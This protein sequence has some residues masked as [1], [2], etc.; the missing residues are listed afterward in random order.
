M[1]KYFEKFPTRTYNGYNV[2]DIMARVKV[3]DRV[4]NRSDYYNSYELMDDVRADNAANQIYGDPYYSWLIYLANSTIDPY[5]DWKLSQSNFDKFI[6]KKYG[7]IRAAQGRV[8]IWMNNWYDSP[9]AISTTEYNSYSDVRKQY[10]L[11]IYNGNYIVEYRRKEVDWSINTNEIWEYKV[12]GDV[13]FE[14]DQKI[15]IMDPN[16]NKV[17]N[18]QVLYSNTSLVRLKNVFGLAS[19][20]DDSVNTYSSTTPSLIANGSY[21]VTYTVVPGRFNVSALYNVNGNENP[22]YNGLHKA[23]ATTNTTITLA[24]DRDPGTSVGNNTTIMQ[25]FYVGFEKDYPSEYPIIIGEKVDANVTVTNAKMVAQNISPEEAVYWSPISYYELEDIRN[26]KFQSI[27][28]MANT[29]SVRASL[30]LKR[31]LNP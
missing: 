19:G 20:A 10:F 22:S 4:Y 25:E 28:L 13:I 2:K 30:E 15:S 5:Y 17:A 9:D 31:L 29:Y 7:N 24:Y 14:M 11:P 21:S 18:G 12:Q 23:I 27:R 8:A 3:L 6:I 16:G 26:S 1:Q